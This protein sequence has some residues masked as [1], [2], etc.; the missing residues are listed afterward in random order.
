MLQV[1]SNLSDIHI[2]TLSSPMNVLLACS[3][4][5]CEDVHWTLIELAL[6]A[7]PP[8]SALQKQCK[9]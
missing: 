8:G 5:N 2:T 7:R 1:F 9:L 3:L 4:K 6:E